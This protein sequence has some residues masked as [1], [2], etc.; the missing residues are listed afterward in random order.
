[1]IPEI[2]ISTENSRQ[3]VLDTVLLGFSSDPFIRWLCP[4]AHNYLLFSEAFNAFGDNAINNQTAYITKNYEGAALWLPPGIEP[5][6]EAFVAE[7]GKNVD[8]TRHEVLFKILEA[9]EEYQPEE[10]FWYLPIIAVDPAYQGQ[11]IGSQL[12]KRALERVDEDSLTAYLE[13]SNPRNM[14]LYKR[15]GFETMG[16]IKIGDAPPIHPMIRSAR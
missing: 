8:P 2:F 12:M 14:S 10:N 9:F 15:Y 6:E 16:Q 3:A 13:S 7:I 4:E 5:N 11:G 1:M